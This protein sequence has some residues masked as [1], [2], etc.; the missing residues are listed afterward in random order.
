[1]I[2]QAVPE[3][4][5]DK[6]SKIVDP[7]MKGYM[8]SNVMMSLI[9]KYRKEATKELKNRTAIL[10]LLMLTASLQTQWNRLLRITLIHPAI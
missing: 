10:M 4:A 2:N 7:L 3:L 9:K 8:D 5:S 6:I 1:M